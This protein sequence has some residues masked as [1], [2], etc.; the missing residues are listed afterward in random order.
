[1]KVLY[2]PRIGLPILLQENMCM[3]RH[4]VYVNRSQTHEFGN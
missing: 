4:W 1:V 2:I 3:D